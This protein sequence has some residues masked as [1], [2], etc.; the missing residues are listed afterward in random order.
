MQQIA[1]QQLKVIKQQRK[2]ACSRELHKTE[3]DKARGTTRPTAQQSK[4]VT[5]M[6]I[7]TPS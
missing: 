4:Q 6:G 7:N 2:N 1:T 3:S 5:I